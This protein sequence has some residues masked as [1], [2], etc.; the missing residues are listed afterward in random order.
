MTSC[1]PVYAVA[2]LGFV[3]GNWNS[4]ALSIQFRKRFRIGTLL[5]RAFPFSFIWKN[6][7]ITSRS[8]NS[9]FPIKFTAGTAF[10]DPWRVILFWAF[11]QRGRYANAENGEKSLTQSVITQ[12]YPISTGKRASVKMYSGGSGSPVEPNQKVVARQVSQFGSFISFSHACVRLN[13]EP[14]K[15]DLQCECVGTEL[16]TFLQFFLFGW[17]DLPVD[18][19]QYFTFCDNMK[20]FNSFMVE[21]NCLN[22]ECVI[23]QRFVELDLKCTPR[24]SETTC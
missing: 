17:A 12:I 6:F 8:G 18:P 19:L 16:R 7:T 13:G 22:A 5:N 24:I 23:P 4:A 21:M 10:A 2:Y 9:I 1:L 3:F 11:C 14:T 15:M 20:K